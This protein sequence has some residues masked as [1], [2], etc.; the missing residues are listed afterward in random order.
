MRD[1]GCAQVLIGLES[2]TARGVDGIELKHNWKRGKFDGYKSA[3][4]KVQSHGITVDGCFVLGLDGDTPE[5][6][7]EVW[8]FVQQSG[9][10]EV[11][12][13]VMTAFPGTPLYDRLRSEGRLLDETGWEKCTLFDVNFRPSQMSV[14]QLEQGLIELGRRLY[15]AE[16]RRSRTGAFRR[17]LRHTTRQ[18]NE[19]GAQN[20]T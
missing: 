19:G 15:S 5:V 9:L 2:P 20:G 12:I 14:S 13:T 18:H 11:Q 3:I 7:D 17:L 10:Y 8:D 1:A 16:S 4:E 6:F